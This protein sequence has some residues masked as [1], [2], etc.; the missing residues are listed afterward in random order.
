MKLFHVRGIFL[1]EEQQ[2]HSH[3]GQSAFRLLFLSD[4]SSDGVC[5]CF[6]TGLVGAGDPV[7]LRAAG[8]ICEIY[9]LPSNASFRFKEMFGAV[10]VCPAPPPHRLYPS[11]IIFWFA[12]SAGIA[13]EWGEDEEAWIIIFISC[14]TCIDQTRIRVHSLENR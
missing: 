13:Q 12:L 10:A 1:S 6:S 11:L 7:C 5:G 4:S 8:D 2:Q 14:S 3:R 9:L